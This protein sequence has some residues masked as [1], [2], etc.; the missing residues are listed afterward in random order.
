MLNIALG[1]MEH[2]HNIDHFLFEVNVLDFRLNPSTT[3]PQQFY[4]LKAL[5]QRQRGI[6]S[7]SCAARISLLGWLSWR[8][9]FG[10]SNNKNIRPFGQSENV[11][12]WKSSIQEN[13]LKLLHQLLNRGSIKLPSLRVIRTLE[14]TN[15]RGWPRTMLLKRLSLLWLYHIAMT[16]LRI[17]FFIRSGKRYN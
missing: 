4:Q 1:Y 3:L 6:S 16:G 8:L 14:A 5:W 9:S 11:Y 10:K 7:L 2:R 17:V 15:Y 13:L 12:R